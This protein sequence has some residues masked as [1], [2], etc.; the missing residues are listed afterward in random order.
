MH[1]KEAEWSTRSATALA[2]VAVVDRE[3]A[4]V[5]LSQPRIEEGASEHH[6]EQIIT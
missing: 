4:A 2:N 5:M 3:V 6:R 1:V